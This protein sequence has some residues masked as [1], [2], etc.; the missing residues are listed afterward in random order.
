MIPEV[1]QVVGGLLCCNI[2]SISISTPTFFYYPHLHHHQVYL[3]ILLMK[4]FSFVICTHIICKIEVSSLLTVQLR[5]RIRYYFTI[6]FKLLLF[7]CIFWEVLKVGVKKNSTFQQTCPLSSDPPPSTPLAKKIDFF[8][9]FLYI[10]Q[11][12]LKKG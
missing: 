11:S 9:F 1:V 8:T 7:F 12:N 2:S 4:C 6:S 10:Y 5:E 3:K